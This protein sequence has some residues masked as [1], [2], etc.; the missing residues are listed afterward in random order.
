MWVCGEG[1]AHALPSMRIGKLPSKQQSKAFIT[2]LD[3]ALIYPSSLE[4]SVSPLVLHFP[5]TN[6][7]HTTDARRRGKNQGDSLRK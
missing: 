2:W 6:H 1:V 4:P 3:L 5:P 7:L